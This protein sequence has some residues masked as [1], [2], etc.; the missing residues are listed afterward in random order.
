MSHIHCLQHVPFEPPAGIADWAAA[1]GHG[2]SITRVFAGDALPDAG[3]IEALVIMG[4]PMSVHDQAKLPWLAPEKRLIAASLDA[5]IPVFGVCLGAQLIA[6]AT[7]ARVH[8]NRFKEIGWFPVE[9]TNEGHGRFALPRSF[10]AFHWHGETFQL[11]AGAVR[12]ARTEACEQQMFA[13][14]ERVLGIQFHLEM[15]REGIADLAV[16]CAG[17]LETGPFV[18]DRDQLVGATAAIAA[19]HRILDLLLDGWIK[20]GEA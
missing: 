4:G 8:R 5:G 6:D 3:A 17:D 19:S 12:L 14:G 1:R 9:A 13:I 2:L 11:P 16:H 10:D 20:G 18:Q 7:G 15:T